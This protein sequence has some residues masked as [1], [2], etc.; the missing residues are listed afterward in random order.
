[1]PELSSW[2]PAL[3]YLSAPRLVF[4]VKNSFGIDLGLNIAELALV[5]GQNTTSLEGPAIDNFPDLAGAEAVG[6]TAWTVHVL[7][8]AG[9]DPDLSDV[10]NT[11]PDSLQLVGTVDILP[12]SANRQFATSTD[13]VSCI[14][15]LE[16][17]LAGWAQGFTWRDTLDTPI[18]EELRAGISPP[19][20]WMDV[21][22][23]TFRFIIDNEWP[24]EL[25]GSVNFINAAGDAL[26][27]GPGLSISGASDD[28][29]TATVDYTLDRTLALEL[30]EMDCAGV[31][32]AWTLATTDAAAGQ[33]VQ[34]YKQDA[35]SMRIA[36][37]VECQI[38][39]TP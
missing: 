16:V 3:F 8:N 27:V 33:S 10:M 34:V 15:A 14:G 20:D 18:S 39:P 38:D 2:N 28:P 35:M 6:D 12:T 29:A 19:L 32:V 23:L 7:D 25:N 22:S 1:M 5:N 26:L 4:D 37:K 11:A 9:M 30:M 13:A 17:P 21:A 36:V 31:A 24:L